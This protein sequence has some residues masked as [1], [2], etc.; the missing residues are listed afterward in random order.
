MTKRTSIATPAAMLAVSGLLLAGICLGSGLAQA[1][2][3]PVPA[4]MP[5]SNDVT[6]PD[7]CGWGGGVGGGQSP[8]GT[9]PGQVDLLPGVT[10]SGPTDLTPGAGTD[11]TPGAGPDVPPVLVGSRLAPSAFWGSASPTNC[12]GCGIAVAGPEFGF[13]PLAG[14]RQSGRYRET[15]YGSQTSL[16]SCPF[17]GFG[18]HRS[19]Q[20][21]QQR[22]GGEAVD[23]ALQFL[24][25]SLL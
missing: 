2:V 13:P 25:G 15:Q 3:A 16:V 4:Q 1:Q 24:A 17:A 14:Q 5:C 20:H 9:G 7:F 23:A 12:F 19:H 6:E 22:T 21:D 18:D 8:F 11:L 10:E